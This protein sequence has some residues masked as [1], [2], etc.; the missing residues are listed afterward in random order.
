MYLLLIF[1][2]GRNPNTKR[3]NLEA[4]GVELDQAGAVKVVTNFLFLQILYLLLQL[5]IHYIIL[6]WMSTHAL[7]YLA[8]GLWEMPQTELTL[9]L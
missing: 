7:I 8:Y 1:A 9:H 5:L 2:T 3:L 4:V 6:R